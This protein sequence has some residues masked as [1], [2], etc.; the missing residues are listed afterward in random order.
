MM[1]PYNIPLA[2]VLSGERE[3]GVWSAAPST[4]RCLPGCQTSLPSK[5][6]L[7]EWRRLFLSLQLVLLFKT[8]ILVA[9]F[10]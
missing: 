7:V 1:F 9:D 2:G 3:A 6:F 5:S 10:L 4:L 8:L